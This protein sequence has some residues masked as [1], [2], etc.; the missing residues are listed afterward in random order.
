MWKRLSYLIAAMALATFLSCNRTNDATSMN[1]EKSQSDSSDEPF[2]LGQQLADASRA[3]TKWRESGAGGKSPLPESEYDF[4]R[5]DLNLI[6]PTANSLDDE[7]RHVCKQYAR[8]DANDRLK[9]RRSISMDQFYTLMNFANRAAV[10]GIRE[11]KAEVVADG[12]TAIAMI[13]QE[14]VDFRDI[15]LCLGLLYHAA[16]KARGNANE[17]FRAAAA[18]SEPEVSGYFMRFIEQTPEYRDLRTSW[19]YDEV[20][21]DDGIGFINWGFSKYNPTIDMTSTI[22]E[23]SKLVSSDS[24]QPSHI[25]VATELPDVWLGSRDNASLQRILSSIRA[26]STVSASLRPDKHSEHRSQQFTIFL[27]E[28]ISDSDAQTLYQ[29]AQENK[30]PSHSKLA[31]AK[32][33]LFCLVVARSFVDGVDS[34]ETNE[35]LTRFSAGLKLILER[36]AGIEQAK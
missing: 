36:R 21:T 5:G 12:L 26:G 4:W 18:L 6:A 34:F 25:E 28:T 15:H 22:I 9:T 1:N 11:S 29:F 3:E 32:S 30:S 16:N 14:R 24:Y 13:E 27:V 2:V 33:R 19:G 8:S 35:S 31:M 10:F 20:Q 17:M 23:I 7:I